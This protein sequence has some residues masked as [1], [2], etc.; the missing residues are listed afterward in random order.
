MHR[1]YKIWALD[2][3]LT[4]QDFFAKRSVSVSYKSV[5]Y[6]RDSTVHS[7]KFSINWFLTYMHFSMGF[8]ERMKV[9]QVWRSPNLQN[10]DWN[11]DSK[12]DL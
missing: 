4:G 5:S 7:N 9:A 10:L 11:I 12:R 3:F 1:H 8:N 6:M 2:E